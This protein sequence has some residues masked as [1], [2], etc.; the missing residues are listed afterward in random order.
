MTSI[1]EGAK[2]L[3]LGPGQRG[4]TDRIDGLAEAARAARGRLPD[5][6]VDAAAE[7]AARAGERFRLSAEHTVVALAGATGSGKSSTFN[8][9]AGLDLA[10]VGVRRPTTSWTMACSWG[11]GAAAG[12]S[13]VGELLDW[14]G[15]PRRHQVS[16][17]SMLDTGDQARDLDGLVLLDLPDHDSTEL[18]HH[19]EV[20][21]LVALADLLV[22]VLDPQKYADAVVHERYLRPMA[23]HRELVMV[24]LNQIDTVRPDRRKVMVSDLQRLLTEDGL[25]GVPVL[26]ISAKTGEGVPALRKAVAK[27]VGAKQAASK[28]LMADVAK[29]AAAMREVN[30]TG[31]PGRPARS[32]RDELVASFEA[33]GAVPTV[34]EAVRAA[35]VA[36]GSRATGWP[37]TAW[38]RRLRPDPLRR[39]H[40][41][42]G[43]RGETLTARPRASLPPASPIERARVDTAVR[44]VADSVG[45]GLARPWAEAVRR[46]S[47]SRLG[48]LEDALDRAVTGADLSVSGTPLSWRLI[49]AVQWLLLVAAVIGGVWLAVLA[50]TGYLRLPEPT[51]PD[52]RGFPLPTAL[53][54]GGL[55]VGVLLGLVSGLVVRWSAARRARSARR[56][57][58]AAAAEVTDRLVVEPIDAEVEAYLATRD[59]LAAALR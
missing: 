19:V 9:L 38:L 13:E 17:A 51:T 26:S 6:V 48:D 4:I 34:V 59:G 31:E 44:E 2:R 50:V 12:A 33:A 27:Q 55:V 40:L 15:V 45:S 36:R 10:A 8:A 5:D 11:H 39:L 25:T 24:V 56:H 30:G 3:V 28:R 47:V 16:R 42:L 32:R 22:W 49:R 57:L 1:V 35:T 52:L 46:A 21:R 29:T 23:T 37:V 58:R 53:L 41:D 7:V 54:V 18:A 14:L 20:D 43:G